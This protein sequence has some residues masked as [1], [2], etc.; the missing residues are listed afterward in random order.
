MCGILLVKS[1]NNIPLELHLEAVKLLSS[2]GP[3]FTRY[4][5]HNNIFIAHTVLHITGNGDYYQQ[6]HANFVAYNGEIYNFNNLEII[7][8]TLNW[9]LIVHHII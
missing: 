1:Q 3:N 8:M 2:R 5:F 9:L 7:A 4:K 6:D